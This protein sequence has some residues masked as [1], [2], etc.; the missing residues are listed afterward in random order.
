MAS[1]D[2]PPP[3]DDRLLSRLGRNI[4][5]L[6]SG[7]GVTGLFSLIYLAV[8]ARALG[9]VQFGIFMVVLTYAQLFA[10]LIQ[11]QSWKGVIRFGAVHVTA[12]ERDRLS[13]LLGF[14]AV[15]DW[16][17]AAAGAVLAA[18]GAFVLA[19]LFGWS[20]DLQHKA[21][22]FAAALLL[23]TGAT[24]T[25]MLRLF[26]R[27]DLLIYCEAF[28][29]TVR[30]IG[31]I[32]VWLAGGGV[33]AFLLVWA[34][35]ALAQ[36][37]ATWVGALLVHRRRLSIGRESLRQAIGENPGLWRFMWQTSLAS[38]F[39]FF[40]VQAGTL[41][42]G[43]FAGP[44]LAGGYRLADRVA[45]SIAKPTETITRALYPELARLVASDD[46]ETLRKLFRRTAGISVA[47]AA[48]VVLIAA[49][50][51][52]LILRL[53]AGKHFEFAQPLL[54]ILSISAAVNIAG[55]SLE[56]FHNAHGR[57]GRVLRARI[58]GTIAYLLLLLVLLP[59]FGA[60]GAAIATA[61][62][63]A[64]IMAQ[65]ALSARNILRHGS[66]RP[67]SPVVANGVPGA[68]IAEQ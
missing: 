50:A 38:S 47:L 44:A 15:L 37:S 65:L 27:F 1:T 63:S 42:V 11:F 49:T 10:N 68:D 13:R 46:R 16:S 7:Q 9:P 52:H 19:P 4:G 41:A 64:V 57:S 31:A 2:Q 29:P 45:T 62:T 5:W 3:T 55:F 58:V 30:L 51:G 53:I 48:A 12:N 59:R 60:E 25:G 34:L 61:I 66:V 54:L 67:S 17:S 40:W 56:P 21:A 36:A 6:L 39:D 20:P 22:I 43:A 24:A 33:S 8:A 35:S 28:S 23:T 18:A 14:T 26:D 32:A